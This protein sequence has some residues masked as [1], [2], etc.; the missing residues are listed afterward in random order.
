VRAGAI[1]HQ[2]FAAADPSPATR[3]LAEILADFS[4]TSDPRKAA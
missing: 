2:A 4:S 3:R 1:P